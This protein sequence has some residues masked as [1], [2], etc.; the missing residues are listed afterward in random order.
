[1]LIEGERALMNRASLMPLL[2][3]MGLDQSVTKSLSCDESRTVAFLCK[4][5]NLAAIRLM[6]PAT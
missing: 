5:A 6:H 1:M 3:L 4:K 2:T